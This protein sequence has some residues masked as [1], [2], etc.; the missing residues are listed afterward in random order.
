MLLDNGPAAAGPPAPPG[1]TTNGATFIS[2]TSGGWDWYSVQLADGRDFTASVVRDEFGA[3]ILRYGTLVGPAGRNEAPARRR[4]GGP[5]HRPLDQSAHGRCLS[6]RLDD[7][8]ARRRFAL[9]PGT[10]PSRPG[11]STPA[12]APAWSIGK[13]PSTSA[14]TMARPAWAMWKLDRLRGRRLRRDAAVRR[15][16]DSRA[17]LTESRNMSARQARIG[18]IGA[19]WWS[20]Y[21]H[22]PGLIENPPRPPGRDL[23]PQRRS[24]RARPP[25]PSPVRP[26]TWTSKPC[27]PRPSLTA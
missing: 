8:S 14:V 20:T 27:S 25:R 26:P 7:F 10:V 23:R 5:S 9:A 12:P 15:T 17:E 6:V 1:S 2:V 3:T 13:A 24:L 22:I 19:G 18:V 16:I 11:N 21:T 4:T